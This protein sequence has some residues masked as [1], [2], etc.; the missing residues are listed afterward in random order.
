MSKK[1]LLAIIVLSVTLAATG[2]IADVTY[3]PLDA[4]NRGVAAQRDAEE[5]AVRRLL[6]QFR[7]IIVQLSQAVAIA[8]RNSIPRGASAWLEVAIE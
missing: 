7:I 4:A 2:A 3:T 1:R 6:D 5:T 8:E